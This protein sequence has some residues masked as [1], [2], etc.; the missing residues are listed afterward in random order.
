MGLVVSLLGREGTI[1]LLEIAYA[2]V[3]GVLVVVV[4]SFHL[5]KTKRK[6][7]K[8]QKNYGGH[9]GGRN[10]GGRYSWAVSCID[11]ASLMLVS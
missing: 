9:Y 6:T 8:T 2:L 4:L 5:P 1:L 11:R 3:T 7:L 10:Y